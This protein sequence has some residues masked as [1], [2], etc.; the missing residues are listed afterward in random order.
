ML[1]SAGFSEDDLYNIWTVLAVILLV[2]NIEFY[3]KQHVDAEHYQ[4]LDVVGPLEEVA[5]LLDCRKEDIGSSLA[6]SIM[7]TAGET[8]ITKNTAQAARDARDAM[9]KALYSRLFSWMVN[10]INMMLG[11]PA[12]ARV[13]GNIGVLDIFGFE[14]LQINSLEQVCAIWGMF[15]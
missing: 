9:G 13:S 12:S 7:V 4:N 3:E 2:G 1:Q 6:T 14:S 15:L 8:I 10:K 11:A 5:D